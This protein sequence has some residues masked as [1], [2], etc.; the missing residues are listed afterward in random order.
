MPVLRLLSNLKKVCGATSPLLGM[1]REISVMAI[2]LRACE[3]GARRYMRNVR[4]P[5]VMPLLRLAERPYRV[6]SITS[7]PD[8]EDSLP[9]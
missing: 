5:E 9:S 2:V 7:Q 1:S 8:L 3:S 4:R 6:C